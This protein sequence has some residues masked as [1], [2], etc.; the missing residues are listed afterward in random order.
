MIERVICDSAA[1]QDGGLA[2]RFKARLY[3]EEPSAFAVRYQGR[4][5]AYL[6][7]CVHIPLELDQK[8]GHIFDMTGQYLVCSVHGA[9][10]A[11]HNGNCLGG[12]CRGPGLVPLQV[13]ERC[14]LV[15]LKEGECN[16]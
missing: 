7:E 15:W 9:F 12:P 11:P 3:G 14:G 16:E 6:N 1:L 4:V 2:V 8:P 13:E 10:F 5:Y